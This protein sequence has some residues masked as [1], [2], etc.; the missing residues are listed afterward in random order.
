MSQAYVLAPTAPRI[1]RTE[2]VDKLENFRKGER[3]EGKGER[4]GGKKVQFGHNEIAFSSSSLKKILKCTHE[5]IFEKQA[6]TF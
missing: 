1:F 6:L 5:R 3:I 4:I 2:K